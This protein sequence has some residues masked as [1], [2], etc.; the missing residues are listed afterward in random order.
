MYELVCMYG[1]YGTKGMYGLGGL[2]PPPK[3]FMFSVV[4]FIV[5]TFLTVYVYSLIRQHCCVFGSW[6]FSYSAVQSPV[7]RIK[8]S[9]LHN[10]PILMKK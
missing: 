1:T 8:T 2:V 4:P 5:C 6:S 10:K 7:L 9:I 3:V